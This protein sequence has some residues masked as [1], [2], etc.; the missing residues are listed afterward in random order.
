[1]RRMLLAL[2]NFTAIVLACASAARSAAAD[3]ELVPGHGY[4]VVNMK[5]GRFN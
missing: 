5:P 2:A 1:M 4:R 3:C